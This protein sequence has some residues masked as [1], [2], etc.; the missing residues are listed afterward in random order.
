MELLKFKTQVIFIQYK[1]IYFFRVY[2]YIICTIS[3]ITIGTFFVKV[4]QVP[5]ILRR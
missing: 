3:A 4:I 5:A 2:I 1:D